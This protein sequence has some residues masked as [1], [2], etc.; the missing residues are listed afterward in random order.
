M[1]YPLVRLK[2]RSHYCTVIAPPVS[3]RLATPDPHLSPLL[4]DAGEFGDLGKVDET[5]TT[6]HGEKSLQLVEVEK[7]IARDRCHW[8]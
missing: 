4:K 2:I 8:C 1:N 6:F 5:I 3:R 7:A